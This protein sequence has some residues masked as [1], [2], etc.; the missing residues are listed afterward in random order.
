MTRTELVAALS[1]AETIFKVWQR[2]LDVFPQLEGIT[3][4]MDT[5]S[6]HISPITRRYLESLGLLTPVILKTGEQRFNFYSDDA[7]QV[8]FSTL[9]LA[10]IGAFWAQYA[11]PSLLPFDPWVESWKRLGP[12]FA[13]KEIQ[14]Q[15]R[16]NLMLWV[17]SGITKDEFRAA[18]GQMVGVRP[19][20]DCGK[21]RKMEQEVVISN[22]YSHHDMG[23]FFMRL[24]FAGIDGVKYV[25]E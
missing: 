22:T 12:I 5:L 15:L 4:S 11:G 19:G 2:H 10:S 13:D 3:K 25:V 21:Y 20:G 8:V 7:C 6:W 16:P 24:K 9:H 1:D 14:I 18:E 23:S 17:V